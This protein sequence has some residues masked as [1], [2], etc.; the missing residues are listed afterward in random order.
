MKAIKIDE[1]SPELCFRLLA[2][3]IGESS[4]CRRVRYDVLAA[5]LGTSEENVRYNIRKL[6]R[7]G[8]LRSYGSHGYEPTEKVIVQN[9]KK[10]A[11]K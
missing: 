4:E 2:V 8:Y 6:I 9:I 11:N 3:I 7:M 10:E 1:R 5:Q